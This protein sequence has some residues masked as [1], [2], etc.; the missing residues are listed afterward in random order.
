MKSLVPLLSCIALPLTACGPSAQAS[1]GTTEGLIFSPP[2][3]KAGFTRL[4]SPVIPDI[5]PGGDVTF[6]QYVMAP[7]DHDV[8]ILE[9]GGYESAYGHHAVAYGTTAGKP[10]GTSGPCGVDE[11]MTG[12][13]LGGI[14]GEGTTGVVLPDNVGFRLARGSSILLNAHFI[15]TGTQT[16][17]G[18]SVLDV[19]FA[20]ADPSRKVA[21]LLTNVTLSI[22]VPSLGTA[23]ADA[24]CTVPRAF[25]FI[26]FGN[27]MHDHGTSVITTLLRADGSSAVVHDDPA[28]TRDMQFNA[29]LDQWPGTAPFHVG[30]GETLRTHC[31]WQNPTP[32]TLA[33]PAEM[34]I[35]F[36]FFLGDGSSSPV[37]IDGTWS[38]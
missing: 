10:V 18:Q 7:L 30:S 15:N 36:G 37:C 34:C 33:F 9:V 31:T 20:D 1:Q 14:G 3:P 24:V 28:W 16:V 4:V 6:C 21:S 19:K 8:D 25:D 29:A 23:S 2:P 22:S 5:E 26:M 11:T 35:G 13:F 38:G 12:G 27:H 32:T 17:S